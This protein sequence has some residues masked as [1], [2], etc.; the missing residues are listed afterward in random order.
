MFMEENLKL[1]WLPADRSTFM[2]ND[3]KWTDSAYFVLFILIAICLFISV[4]LYYYFRK[5]NQRTITFGW[6]Y[7]LCNFWSFSSIATSGYGSLFIWGLFLCWSKCSHF[8]GAVCCLVLLRWQVVLW[9]S[10]KY[11]FIC[12]IFALLGLFYLISA[13]SVWP[14]F[15]FGPLVITKL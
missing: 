15:H 13:L 14:L 6:F 1:L 9:T 7:C 3:L 2:T 8:T 12:Q 11:T 4:T 10:S 5:Y